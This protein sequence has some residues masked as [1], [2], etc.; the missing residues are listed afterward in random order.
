MKE[1]G[2]KA[3]EYVHGYKRGVYFAPFYDNYKEY[4]TSQIDETQLKL[5]ERLTK[6]V[7][8]ILE[9]WKPKAINRYSRLYDENKINDEILY[10]NKMPYMSWQEAR[11]LF[12]K[13]VGR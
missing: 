8:A 1:V 5:K 11:N 3:S 9:W 7:D 10:Y 2:I 12:L 13:D 4:L 6:D